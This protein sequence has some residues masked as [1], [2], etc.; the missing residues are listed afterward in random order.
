[1]IPMMPSLSLTYV[2]VH[3]IAIMWYPTQPTIPEEEEDSYYLISMANALEVF[4]QNQLRGDSLPL[5]CCLKSKNT[6][7]AA[8][9]NI[10]SHKEYSAKILNN[11]IKH[12]QFRFS[13]ERLVITNRPISFTNFECHSTEL[14]R[15]YPL[16]ALLDQVAVCIPNKKK[17]KNALLP[18]G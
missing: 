6:E 12:L 9:C 4:D 13:L 11:I 14:L 8:I 1:M 5:K 18:S 7:M 2:E 15:T 3:H 17:R 16:D 10:L